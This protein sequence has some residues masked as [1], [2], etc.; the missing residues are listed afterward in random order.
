MIMIDKAKPI[1]VTGA[2]GYVAGWLVKKLLEEGFVVHAPVRN[3]GNKE[4][5]AH[6]NGCASELPG[7]IKF[8][9]ADLLE[10]GSYEE[11]MAGCELIFHTASPFI[12]TVS[13]PQ[14]DLVDPA[15]KG[16]KNVLNT[17]NKVESVKRV[18]LT[19]SIAAIIGDA[20]E[21]NDNQPVDESTWN[22]TSNLKHQ[23]YSYSKT[24]AEKEA[25]KIYEAQKRWELVVVNPAL[26]LGPSVGPANN[27]ESFNILRQL[28]DGTARFGVPNFHFAVVDVRDVAIAHFKAGFKDAK[29]RHIITSGGAT[30]LELSRFIRKKYGN[31]YPLPRWNAPMWIVWIIA[32][33]IGLKREMVRLNSGYRWN[34]DNSKSKDT[35]GM[36]YRTIEESIVDFFD[37][38]V[39]NG[40]FKK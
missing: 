19:S 5:L 28:G 3:P 23:A 14:K 18:V 31:Q 11:A 6:L 20:C 29:G 25:W 39:E 12:N 13:D 33:L 22:S 32:P 35:L 7:E 1:M 34:L 15:L 37:Q 21:C 4:K 16:T 26:V 36:T 38:L 24:L 40:M 17:A 2:T 8:F 30:L 9:K 10:E 27:S